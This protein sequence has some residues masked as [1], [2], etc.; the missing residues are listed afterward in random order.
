MEDFC[1]ASHIY[2]SVLAFQTPKILHVP[3]HIF[4]GACNKSIDMK[5]IAN[6]HLESIEIYVFI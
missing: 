3:N 1:R 5:K 4:T 2:Q 6:I